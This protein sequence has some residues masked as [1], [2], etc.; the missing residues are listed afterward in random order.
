MGSARIGAARITGVALLGHFSAEG[1]LGSGGWVWVVLGFGF[2]VGSA[3]LGTA[4]TPQPHYA[5]EGFSRS[6][7][8][9]GAP[10]SLGKL[11]GGGSGRPEKAQLDTLVLGSYFDIHFLI[12]AIFL[13]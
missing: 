11:G 3:W 10:A 8:E 9:V 5:G 13:Y 4:W 2:R 6:A 7:S 12:C 1:R